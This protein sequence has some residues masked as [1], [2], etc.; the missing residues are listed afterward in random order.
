MGEHLNKGYETARRGKAGDEQYTPAYAVRP[1]LK[2][3]KPNAVIW[4]PCDKEDS[5]YVKIFRKHGHKVIAS[6]IDNEQDFFHYEPDEPYDVII[7]NPPFSVK[8][9][10]VRRLYELGKPYAVLMPIP[11]LQGQKRFPYI[12]DCQALIF[13]KRIN[14][15]ADGNTKEILK[16]ISFG[17][18]Y[19]CKDF[20]PRDLIFEEL[21]T[22]DG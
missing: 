16:G 15:Y 3:L 10:V 19:L 12:C 22:E 6:H 20:L 14:Y 2:Y 13:D 18:F 11:A 8:D 5:A 1:L 9:L 21:I 17:T 7:T 4:C